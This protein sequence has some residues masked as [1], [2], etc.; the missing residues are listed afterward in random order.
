MEPYVKDVEKR[1]LDVAQAIM[2]QAFARETGKNYMSVDALGRVEAR[3]H[4]ED[5][6]NF[7]A[8]PQEPF[9]AY[10]TAH[11]LTSNVNEDGLDGLIFAS[12]YGYCFPHCDY[13]FLKS[14]TTSSARAL[15]DE[16]FSYEKAYRL[17]E[18]KCVPFG[19]SA[20]YQIGKMEPITFRDFGGIIAD[21]T[22]I[23]S[24]KGIVV[25]YVYGNPSGLL[26]NIVSYMKGI[27]VPSHKTRSDFCA[28]F[29]R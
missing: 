16:E 2:N 20:I 25:D 21:L 24:G 8:P 29:N 19:F 12:T 11:I 26:S 1:A 14:W 27:D 10:S 15:S 6:N 17:D 23:E 7:Q 5:L 13:R 18:N 4:N 28:L 3:I 9:I 22:I